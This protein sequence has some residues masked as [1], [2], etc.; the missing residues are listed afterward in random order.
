M[1]QF[2]PGRNLSERF[3]WEAVQPILSTTLDRPYAACFL[4]PGSDVQGYDDEISTDHGWGPRVQI[5][6]LGDVAEVEAIE[7][8]LPESFLGFSLGWSAPYYRPVEFWTMDG[9]LQKTLGPAIPSE[10]DPLAWLIVTQQE[11]RSVTRPNIFHDEVGFAQRVSHLKWFPVDIARYLMAS[12][13]RRIGQEEHLTGRAG[14][15]GDEKRRKGHCQPCRPGSDADLLSL[16]RGLCS[17]SEV[18]WDRFQ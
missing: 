1:P 14:Q 11:L 2:I 6:H 5:L 7:E 18:V 17:L 9:F 8:R 3:F 4:G 12:L 13:W 10:K 15:V 16:G